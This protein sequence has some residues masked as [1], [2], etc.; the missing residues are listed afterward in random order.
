MLAEAQPGQFDEAAL[1]Q[2]AWDLAGVARRLLRIQR[3]LL[4][5]GVP[6]PS[7]P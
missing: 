1:S 6:Q 4:G 3:D 2:G 7:R 5:E